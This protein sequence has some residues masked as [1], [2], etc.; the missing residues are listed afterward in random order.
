MVSITSSGLP[1]TNSSSNESNSSSNESNS[2]SSEE[3]SSESTPAPLSFQL[4]QFTCLNNRLIQFLQLGIS[5]NDNLLQC[6]PSLANLGDVVYDR[7][8]DYNLQFDDLSS[9]YALLLYCPSALCRLRVGFGLITDVAQ[10]AA[11]LN[12]IQ[13]NLRNNTTILPN[14]SNG[15]TLTPARLNATERNCINGVVD[16]VVNV[17]N[18]IS[19]C[20]GS[21]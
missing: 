2:S 8:S 17:F 16:N 10:I 19:S 11:D 14:T 4:Q 18:N 20:F 21:N 15:A 9:S 13:Y 6:T 12:A 3:D 7:V 1:V 5:F